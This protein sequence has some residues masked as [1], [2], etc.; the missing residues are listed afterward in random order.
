MTTVNGTD[1]E[2]Y[3]LRIEILR[4]EFAISMWRGRAHRFRRLFIGAAC[5]A[6]ILGVAAVMEALIWW[7]R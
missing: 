2:N 6:A 5:I 4:M 1:T 7:A 3:D